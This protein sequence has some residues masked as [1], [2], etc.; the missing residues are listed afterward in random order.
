MTDA[1]SSPT[2]RISAA[3]LDQALASAMAATR[4]DGAHDIRLDPE[5]VQQ[6]IA[7]LVL[8][9][10]EFVRR[11]LE[12]QAVRRMQAGTLT[13]DEEERVGTTL[14]LA[15]EQIRVLTRQFGIPDEDLN[16]DLGP[17]GKLM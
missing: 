13:A 4:T 10:I 7:K 17:L 8:T 12:L 16:L 9:L 11:L 2:F 3:D 1:A 5:T 6:D 14:M 15:G